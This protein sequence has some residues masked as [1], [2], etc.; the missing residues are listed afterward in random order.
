VRE[1]LAIAFGQVIQRLRDERGWSQETLAE[2]SDRSRNLIARFEQGR[3]RPSVE[4]LWDLAHAFKL[5]PSEI[6]DLA[7]A[8]L[9][10]N[11]RSR[12]RPR[13]RKPGRPRKRR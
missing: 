4:S 12:A 6:V 10:R 3:S 2:R 13:P 9:Q 8:Q 11:R 1:D 5:R 7:E